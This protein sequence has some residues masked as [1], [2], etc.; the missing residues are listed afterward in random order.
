MCAGG[1][2]QSWR[3][4]AGRETS[5]EPSYSSM[6]A[7]ASTKVKADSSKSHLVLLL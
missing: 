6:L 2:G 7:V 1:E 5:R 3:K 4:T